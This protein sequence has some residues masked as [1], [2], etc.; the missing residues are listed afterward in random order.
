MTPAFRILQTVSG[1]LLG[2]LICVAAA[3]A[4]TLS[5]IHARKQVRIAID[6]GVPPF[7]MTDATMQPEG[8]DVDIARMIAKDLGVELEMVPVTGPDR[9]SLLLS[10]KADMV[11]S[12][13]SITPAREK[14]IAFS[15]PYGALLLVIA[16]PRNV[17]IHSL[18]DLAGKRVGVVRGNLQDTVLTPV[19]PQGTSIARYDD[20]AAVDAALLSGEIDALCSV[21]SLVQT[22][23]RR[24]PEKQL[25]IKFQVHLNPY[26][27]GVR[28]QDTALLQW[29][30]QWITTNMKNG[31]LQ[32]TYVKWMR[33]PFPDLD[34][35]EKP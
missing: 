7:G 16:A 20:D 15:K 13:F 19:A 28:Q 23:A 27:I 21:D 29:L 10:G 6:L 1:M 34:S 2:A 8:S 33:S 30:N 11:I 14:L 9:I 12:S 3:H 22:L 31:R 4:D 17:S 35:F 32:Q 18:S 26:A 5:D 24:H 25:E